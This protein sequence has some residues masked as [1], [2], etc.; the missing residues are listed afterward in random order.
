MEL[1][2]EEHIGGNWSMQAHKFRKKFSKL[3]RKWNKNV[4]G[5][6][7]RPG[8]WVEPSEGIE[9]WNAGREHCFNALRGLKDSMAL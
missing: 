4:T 1:F 3:Q 6:Y 8:S 2:V 5:N 7:S 9:N